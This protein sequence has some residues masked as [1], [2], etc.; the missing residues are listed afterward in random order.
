MQSSIGPCTGQSPV[1]CVLKPFVLFQG[2][3]GG[4]EAKPGFSLASRHMLFR[5]AGFAALVCKACL[6]IV[7]TASR[8]GCKAPTG[9]LL[10]PHRR[11]R[12]G[13]DEDQENQKSETSPLSSPAPQPSW[14]ESGL[15]S[16][17]PPHLRHLRYGRNRMTSIY[18]QKAA[19]LEVHWCKGGGG[20]WSRAL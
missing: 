9:H 20:L 19:L 15:W 18:A 12:H 4:G 6:L 17:F 2:R 14:P 3:K 11:A 13:E 16:L 1:S 7:T 10:P 5:R 8:T